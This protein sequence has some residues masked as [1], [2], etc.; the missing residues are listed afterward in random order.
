MNSAPLK[1]LV[2]PILFICFSLHIRAQ[3]LTPATQNLANKLAAGNVMAPG[4]WD[5]RYAKGK[6]LINRNQYVAYRALCDSA[7]LSE[8]IL[9]LNHPNGVV[10]GYAGWALAERKYPAC[11]SI[12]KVF[13]ESEEKIHDAINT[14]KVDLSVEFYFGVY[15]SNW[16]DDITKEDTLFALGMIKKLDSI[17]LYLHRPT[18]LLG[19]ALDHNNADPATYEQVRRW[20]LENKNEKAIIELARY[21]KQEDIAILKQS[22]KTILQCAAL[23]PDEQFWPCLEPYFSQQKTPELFNAVA[24]YKDQRS[25]N[26]LA[27]FYSQINSIKLV[28]NLYEAI[29]TNYCPY[30]NNLLEMIWTKDKAIEGKGATFLAKAD[31]QKAATI[32]TKGL[33]NKKEFHYIYL[34]ERYPGKGA[35]YLMFDNISVYNK[36]QLAEVISSCLNEKGR[37]L[38]YF[39]DYIEANN[40][41]GLGNV[42]LNKFNPGHMPVGDILRL[43]KIILSYKEEQLSQEVIKILKAYKQ[44]RYWHNEEK[45]ILDLLKTFNMDLD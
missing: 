12:F 4:T 15:Y 32:F 35:L 39:L 33:L 19:I 27:S 8:L 38:S 11:D 34:K 28:E 44:N 6:D 7:D 30:Y 25:A 3:G 41:E 40:V 14:E 31:P 17:M 5:S 36:Q 9:L 21:K 42:L 13:L 20:A 1:V 26:T 16:K 23:F 29:I 2:F 22:G 24:A 18:L 45:N 43:I 10:K 37:V